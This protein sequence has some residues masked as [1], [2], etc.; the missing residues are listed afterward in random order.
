MG[1]VSRGRD[2]VSQGGLFT[3]WRA[4]C[5]FSLC[6]SLSSPTPL[7][8]WNFPEPRDFHKA[9]WW[10]A[11]SVCQGSCAAAKRHWSWF[12]ATTRTQV[13]MSPG[14]Q[15]REI[16]SGS[17]G[18]WLPQDTLSVVGHQIVALRRGK[19]GTSYSATMSMSFLLILFICLLRNCP[20]SLL[21]WFK[22]IFKL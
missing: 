2:D 8:C 22:N 11:G 5:P 12:Q 1:A 7:V 9:G 19:E 13:C 3:L 21:T 10:P 20:N 6:L 4:W 14:A 16:L 15:V 18:I 17:L